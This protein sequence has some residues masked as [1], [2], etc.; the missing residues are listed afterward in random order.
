MKILDGQARIA[1]IAA[2]ATLLASGTSAL[3]YMLAKYLM[4]VGYLNQ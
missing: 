1:I 2:Y 4:L 3:E